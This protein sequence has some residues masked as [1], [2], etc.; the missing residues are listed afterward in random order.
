MI[1][2]PPDATGEYRDYKGDTTWVK[3]IDLREPNYPL[4][5]VWSWSSHRWRKRRELIELDR[6]RLID[7]S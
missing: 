1:D 5:F 2:V 4:A 6:L 3:G 7:R